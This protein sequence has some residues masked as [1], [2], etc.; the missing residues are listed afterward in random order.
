MKKIAIIWG[1]HRQTKPFHTHHSFWEAA[2]KKR[3]NVQ[4]ERFT[5]GEWPSI[6]SGFDFYFFV[7]FHPSLFRLPPDRLRPRAF[8]WWDCFH[9]SLSYVGRLAELFD[10]T[11]L[12][13]KQTAK[14]LKANG[15][16]HASWLPMAFHPA[17]YRP[18]EG[19]KKVHQYAFI[20]QQDDVV[21]HKGD[22]R[23]GFLDRLAAERHLH[24]Y[25]GNGVFGD[26]VNQIY[27]ESAVLF[28]RTIWTNL[29]ARFFEGIG[30][31]SFFLMNRGSVDNGLDEMATDGEHFVSYDGSFKDFIE[32]LG[33]YLNNHDLR[34]RIAQKGRLY[35]LAKHTYASRL[36]VILKDMGIK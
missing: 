10:R 2:L 9:Y 6:S 7:D 5:W 24:G 21:V 23:K 8:Y 1:T 32:K 27:N 12:A 18:L 11:Y 30:S 25:F 20:G 33:F 22:T 26:Q 3:H 19:A 28:D 16:E 17:L 13:E 36:E 15:V 35:F 4:T 14:I 34:E 29:G 31:G